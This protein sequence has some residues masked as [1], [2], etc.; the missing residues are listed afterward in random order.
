[1][2]PSVIKTHLKRSGKSLLDIVIEIDG[3]PSSHSTRL[4]TSMRIVMP[5][6]YRWRTLD[7]FET[8]VYYYNSDEDPLTV[9][10][11]LEEA[12]HGL[13]FPS[14]KRASIS[15]SLSTVHPSFL[16]PTGALLLE[17]LV[18]NDCQ[19][20]KD[21]APPPTLKTLKLSFE[22]I[23]DPRYTPLSYSNSN[24]DNALTLR[25]D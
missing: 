21:F 3:S 10:E 20:W 16:S 9:V 12:I 8:G 11:F 4:D 2:S 5:H 19:A 24:I 17:K 13:E 6:V 18:L 22:S 25:D 23:V 14:L 1:M 7:V 15:C